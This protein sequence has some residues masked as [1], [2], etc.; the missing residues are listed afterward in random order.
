MEKKIF[1]KKLI[2]AIVITVIISGLVG[3]YGG[4]YHERIL[5][6]KNFTQR[7]DITNGQFRPNGGFHQNQNSNMQPNA[8][9]APTEPSPQPS[10]N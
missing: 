10:T 7:R 2:I 5:M 8:Q 3:Y 9:P 1:D 4:R 6:R